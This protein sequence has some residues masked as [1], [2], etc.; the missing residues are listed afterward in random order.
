M[1]KELQNFDGN[2]VRSRIE[3][4]DRCQSKL[5]SALIEHLAEAERRKLY[6]GWGFNSLFDYLTVHLKYSEG[7]ANRRIQAARALL[8]MPELLEDIQEKTLNLTQFA[9]VQ[10]CIRQEEK[11]SGEKVTASRK[12]EI[13]DDL[14]NKTG[15]ETQ[16]ILDQHLPSSSTVQPIEKHKCDGSVEFNLRVSESTYQKLERIREL[17]SHMIFDGNWLDVIDKMCDDV[18]ASRDPAVKGTK[19]STQRLAKMAKAGRK[20]ACVQ[21]GELFGEA[22]DGSRNES[23]QEATDE[24]CNEVSNANNKR[25]SNAGGISNLHSHPARASETGTSPRR[26]KNSQ[27]SSERKFNSS[28]RKAISQPIRRTI[29]QRDG[30]C[31]HQNPDGSK[32][33]SRYQLE[34]DHVTPVFAGGTDDPSNLRLLCRKHNQFRYEQGTGIQ[35]GFEFHSHG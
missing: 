7:S 3:R 5:T 1:N 22:S 8:Q 9:Q 33:M 30:G 28:F 23:C 18:I 32:C 35:A 15:K 27:T 24:V 19:K 14:R 17:Y 2:K 29:F 25:S 13:F 26:P 20:T 21:T 31:Q 12:A 11:V 6:F 34:I 4:I 10:A 16:K